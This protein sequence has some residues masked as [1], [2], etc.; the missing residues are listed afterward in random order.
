MSALDDVILTAEKLEPAE[1]LQLIKRLWRSIPIDY[2]PPLSDMQL[3]DVRRRLAKLGVEPAES[4][5]WPIVERLLS[6]CARS[7]GNQVFA[8]PRRF[9]LFTIFVI[10]IAFSIL[11]A[12]M[13]LLPL[14]PVAS[15][16]VGGYFA[17]IGLGQ[18]FLFR[19]N[20]PRTASLLVGGLYYVLV[21]Y[22]LWQLSGPR[23]YPTSDVVVTA[24]FLLIFGAVLGF[25]AGA[26]VGSVFMLADWLRS[27]TRE[28]LA[29]VT[30]TSHDERDLAECNEV[31]PPTL[32]E[33]A[34]I[35]G[36]PT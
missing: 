7:S 17:L 30:P 36:S 16:I 1:R 21:S 10:T 3:A 22:V 29:R 18:A 9:D 25:V 6:D 31:E 13:R 24:I 11:F 35:S 20:R 34:P 8:A 23:A 27:V 19:G 2:W 15:A 12:G 14:P 26:L 28:R 5:P 4:V 32:A 33:A